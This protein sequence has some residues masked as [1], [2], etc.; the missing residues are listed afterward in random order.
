MLVKTKDPVRRA[1]IWSVMV[2]LVG[3]VLYV[4]GFKLFLSAW[5]T[6]R[7][8]VN[9]ISI[10]IDLAGFILLLPGTMIIKVFY[11][12]ISSELYL[13]N[14]AVSALVSAVFYFIVFL[15]IFRWRARRKASRESAA[16]K[17]T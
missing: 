11:R 17:G 14:P 2:T 3:Y 9:S 4:L 5:S 12:D 10:A 8:I 13:S 15:L 6:N 7:S 16:P 1:A